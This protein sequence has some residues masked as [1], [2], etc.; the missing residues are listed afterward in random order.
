MEELNPQFLEN[1]EVLGEIQE[2]EIVHQDPFE[3]QPQVHQVQDEY[4]ECKKHGMSIDSYHMFASLLEQQLLGPTS[5][6]EQLYAPTLQCLREA[7]A[8]YK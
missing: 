6:E 7:K 4:K 3:D 1:L 5:W 2:D 8:S